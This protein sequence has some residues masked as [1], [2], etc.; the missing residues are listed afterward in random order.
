M[1]MKLSSMPKSDK[2]SVIFIMAVILAVL[3]TQYAV[4]IRKD[5]DV[6]RK[7]MTREMVIVEQRLIFELAD[8][9]YAVS[10]MRPTAVHMLHHP[11]SLQALTHRMVRFISNLQAAGIAFEPYYFPEHGKWYEP[12]SWRKGNTVI[13][14]QSGGPHHDYFSMDWYREGL[15]AD[16]EHGHW[17]HPYQ[18]N[19]Q[20]N[21]WVTTFSM[22]LFDENDSIIGVIA[23]DVALDTLRR[24][25]KKSEPYKGSVCRLNDLNGHVIAASDSILPDPE[26][27]FTDSMRVGNYDLMVHLS[28]PKKAIYGNT[29]LMELLTL[30]LMSVCIALLIWIGRRSIRSISELHEARESQ[31]ELEREMEVAHNIQMGILRTDFPPG[32][33]A[34]LLPMQEVGG[35]LYDFCERDGALW[36]IVGDV[37]GKGVPAAMMMGATVTLFRNAVRRCEAP[38]DIVSEINTTLSDHNPNLMFVTA[39]VGRLDRRHGLLTY[40]C[41]GHNPPVLNGEVMHIDPDI[42]AGFRSDY[43]YRQHTCLF[44]AGSRLVLYTDGIT[45]ARNPEHEQMGLRRLRDIILSP[46]GATVEET[47]LRIVEAT[48]DF[49]EDCDQTDDMTVMCIV[50]DRAPQQPA[51][52]LS[53]TLSE[54]TRA[55]TLL[56]AY[57]DAVG[58]TSKQTREVSLALEEALANVINY[59][60]PEGTSGLITLDITASADAEGRRIAL[61]LSDRGAPFDPTAQPEAD[62]SGSI[63]ARREG[64][65]GILF[66]KTLMDD[67]SYRRCDDGCNILSM[68][69]T[70]AN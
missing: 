23:T 70:F 13:D 55:K 47:T 57:C 14:E 43:R 34:H 48:C 40:C 45:E 3:V 17:T 44:P 18:D 52:T 7:R 31:R 65:L 27:C 33:S 37:S 69:K 26:K 4:N 25:L 53:N 38:A 64:G 42:P 22:P 41:A 56:R 67:V 5:K 15:T 60:Y 6:A 1:T 12:S 46:G 11:D 9:E 49:C 39:F 28:C 30:G 68:T 10:V 29:I 19:T 50:N 21:K 51:L 61:T 32:V 59:A 2:L 54:L 66:Y 8:A 16:P 35:D 36:F 24:V 63:D 62:V 58:L 20:D